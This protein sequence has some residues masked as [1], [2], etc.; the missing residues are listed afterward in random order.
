MSTKTSRSEKLNFPKPPFDLVPLRALHGLSRVQE[1]GLTKHGAGDYLTNSRGLEE[2]FAKA[3]RHLTSLQAGGGRVDE[4]TLVARDTETG[5]PE[6][7]HALANLVMLRD[8]LIE[9]GALPVDPGMGIGKPDMGTEHEASFF[10]HGQ[11]AP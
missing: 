6:L 2:F 5:L 9:R 7:D 4:T 11:D 3:L 1:F 10:C 8:I